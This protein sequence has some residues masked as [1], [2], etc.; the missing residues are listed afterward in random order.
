MQSR[1]VQRAERA[2]NARLNS[3][4]P[5]DDQ[6]PDACAPCRRL[7]RVAGVRQVFIVLGSEEVDE[8]VVEKCGQTEDQQCRYV[9]ALEIA[10]RLLA[11]HPG[12][13]FQGSPK[14]CEEVISGPGGV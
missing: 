4:L 7:A 14:S 1:S 13:E 3:G 6:P 2:E 8:T 9:V 5:T 10:L 11:D 12:W